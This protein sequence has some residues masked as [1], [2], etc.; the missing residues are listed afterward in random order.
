MSGA[1]L[2]AG[3]PDAAGRLAVLV[4]ELAGMSTKEESP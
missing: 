1:A 4:G 2:A 3:V